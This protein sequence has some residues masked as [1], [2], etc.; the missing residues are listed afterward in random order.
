MA[1]VRNR[2]VTGYSLQGALNGDRRTG[3]WVGARHRI[4]P[5]RR[6]SPQEADVLLLAEGMQICLGPILKTNL[7]MTQASVRF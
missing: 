2:N 1:N 5:F 6:F 7:V 4:L 3:S